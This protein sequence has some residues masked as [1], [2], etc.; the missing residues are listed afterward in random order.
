MQQHKQ[1]REIERASERYAES[2]LG[3]KWMWSFFFYFGG[4]NE[5]FRERNVL[6]LSLTYFCYWSCELILVGR[7]VRSEWNA[8]AL[9]EREVGSTTN[10]ERLEDI[11]MQNIM[12][13]DPSLS[14]FFFHIRALNNQKR[15]YVSTTSK[16]LIH[17]ST[18]TR[19]Y[20]SASTTKTTL[21]LNAH[22]YRLD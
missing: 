12:I 1:Y 6:L 21:L 9:N 2:N 8:N 18:D 19:Y 20:H 15:V 7:W 10:F 4:E 5:T 16:N 3:L 14:S 17:R 22:V 11:H 13:R